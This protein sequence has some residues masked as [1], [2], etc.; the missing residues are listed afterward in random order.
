MLRFP[1]EARRRIG[2]DSTA[3]GLSVGGGGKGRGVGGGGAKCLRA[4][5]QRSG[6][7][8]QERRR[9]GRRAGTK[10]KVHMSSLVR[11]KATNVGRI[12]T[13]ARPGR[14]PGGGLAASGRLC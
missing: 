9:D 10:G 2:A 1:P 4:A 5:G 3:V 13:G 14:K 6:G 8:R 12:Y 7:E 11:G